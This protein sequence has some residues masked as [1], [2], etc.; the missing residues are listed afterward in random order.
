NY[1]IAIHS[2]ALVLKNGL[3]KLFSSFPKCMP[4]QTDI[5]TFLC[6]FFGAISSK[7]ISG[8]S[9][10]HNNIEEC[11]VAPIALYALFVGWY[12]CVPGCHLCAE[13]TLIAA[14]SLKCVAD[15]GFILRS[16]P[17]LFTILMLMIFRDLLIDTVGCAVY[18]WLKIF[19]LLS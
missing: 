1:K 5:A 14:V 7:F 17:A 3:L 2:I 4:S 13:T 11:I 16:V 6:I 8:C 18:I 19:L 10:L 12:F 9:I 15:L